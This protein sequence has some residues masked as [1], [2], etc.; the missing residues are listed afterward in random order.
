MT[1]DQDQPNTLSPD[2]APDA[3]AAQT[4]AASAQDPDERADAAPDE[5]LDSPDGEAQGAADGQA[6]DEGPSENDSG[7]PDAQEPAE[8]ESGDSDEGQ[9]PEDEDDEETKEH[10]PDDAAEPAPLEEPEPAPPREPGAALAHDGLESGLAWFGAEPF[11]PP[12][13]PG[14]PPSGPAAAAA[15]LADETAGV[16]VAEAPALTA[17][18]RRQRMMERLEARRR[19]AKARRRWYQRVPIPVWFTLPATVFII[20]WILFI[21]K[22]W[23]RVPEPSATIDDALLAAPAAENQAEKL[24]EGRITTRDNCF[25]L[26]ASGEMVMD[27]ARRWASFDVAAKAEL[28][29]GEVSCE[30]CLLGQGVDAK[31]WLSLDGSKQVALG[32]VAGGHDPGV[33]KHA[34][35]KPTHMRLDI[36]RRAWYE[37]RIRV[38]PARTR[39]FIN[40]YELRSVATRP[41]RIA[42]I[43]LIAE[44][45]R[46]AFRNW[47]ITP[48]E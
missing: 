46:A 23:D 1:D 29:N 36:E 12:L 25:R 19:E 5:P 4:G 13:A 45:A 20:Y 18:E 2:D 44:E 16:E 48:I 9:E 39:Y 7:A 31:V 35:G 27:G 15:A 42:R 33:N 10:T 30:V 22:P 38:E 14:M 37:L 6:P 26:V 17:A 11:V 41:Q 43:V 24:A 47:T 32:L 3:D 28:E 8:G 34:V 21:A 40:G